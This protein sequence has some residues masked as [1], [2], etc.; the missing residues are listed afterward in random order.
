MI[1]STFSKIHDFVDFIR[2]LKTID[3][4]QWEVESTP[5]SSTSLIERQQR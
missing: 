1:N 4:S 2:S 5:L 3:I